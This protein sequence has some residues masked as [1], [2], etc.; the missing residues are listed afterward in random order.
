MLWEETAVEGVPQRQ[1]ACRVEAQGLDLPGQQDVRRCA[2][3]AA[4]LSAGNEVLDLAWRHARILYPC[5]A[6]DKL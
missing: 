5:S 1:L 6:S 4:A 2:G 3:G